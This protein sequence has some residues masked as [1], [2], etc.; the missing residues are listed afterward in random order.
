[1][2]FNESVPLTIIL[3]DR[4]PVRI[5]PA[6]WPII[7]RANDEWLDEPNRPRWTLVVRQHQDGRSIVY[8]SHYSKGTL[9]PGKS[10]GEILPPASDIFPAMLRVAGVIGAGSLLA[11][12]CLAALPAEDIGSIAYPRP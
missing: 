9:A 7:A 5:N 10:G 12:E 3:S 8:G 1:M 2:P 6:E 11:R 4:A